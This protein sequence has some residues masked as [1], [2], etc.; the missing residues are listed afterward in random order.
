M[1]C[2]NLD[3]NYPYTNTKSYIILGLIL[4]Y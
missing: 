1:Y 4:H 2:E 3:E